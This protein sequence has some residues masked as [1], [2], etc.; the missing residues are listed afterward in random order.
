MQNVPDDSRLEWLKGDGKVGWVICTQRGNSVTIAAI[1][2]GIPE[3]DDVE[4]HMRFFATEGGAGS[5]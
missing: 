3:S 2:E 5:S 4:F 1:E